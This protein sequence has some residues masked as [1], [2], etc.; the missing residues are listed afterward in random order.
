MRI[1]HQDLIEN[2]Q[3]KKITHNLLTYTVM[4][5]YESDWHP[6]TENIQLEEVVAAIGLRQQCNWGS[7]LPTLL[8]MKFV[9]K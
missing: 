4:K 2:H 7:H 6:I 5:Y 9:L 8:F 1:L 3:Y